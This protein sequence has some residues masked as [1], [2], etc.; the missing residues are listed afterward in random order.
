MSSVLTIEFDDVIAKQGTV[1]ALHRSLSSRQ[2]GLGGRDEAP[3]LQRRESMR[4]GF[5]LVL[6]TFEDTPHR[7]DALIFDDGDI[8]P[9]FSVRGD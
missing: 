9:D 4:G 8:I 5:A 6:R 1:E 2:F 7:L 3:V